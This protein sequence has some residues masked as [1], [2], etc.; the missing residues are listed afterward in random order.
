MIAIWDET[1]NKFGDRG[2]IAVAEIIS[3]MPSLQK[4]DLHCLILII[5]K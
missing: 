3:H 5:N 4:L 2:A 1:D